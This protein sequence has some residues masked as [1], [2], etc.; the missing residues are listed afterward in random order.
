MGNKRVTKRARQS[1]LVSCPFA[2]NNIAGRSLVSVSMQHDSHDN[3]DMHH[4][5]LTALWAND[6]PALRAPRDGKD[7]KERHGSS[8]H[9]SNCASLGV[10]LYATGARSHLQVTAMRHVLY[11]IGKLARDP[12]SLQILRG[13]D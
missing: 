4:V 6:S 13:K 3:H 8:M 7:L 5:S 12:A 9:R 2:H 10:I 11:P 1:P